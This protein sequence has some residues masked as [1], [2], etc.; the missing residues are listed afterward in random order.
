[1][2]KDFFLEIS[3]CFT[4]TFT[5][6][7]NCL[8]LKESYIHTIRHCSV[9]ESLQ[10]VNLM[11]AVCSC[12]IILFF[13]NRSSY[14]KMENDLIVKKFKPNQKIKINESIDVTMRVLGVFLS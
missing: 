2:Q 10:I 13:C 9:S 11:R 14:S 3:H 5:L 4:P 8:A 6:S 12:R 1:M 7:T